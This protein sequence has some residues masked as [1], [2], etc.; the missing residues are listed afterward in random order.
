M[1]GIYENN[2]YSLNLE[3]DTINY[4]PTTWTIVHEIDK[5]SPLLQYSKQEISNLHGELIIMISYYDESFNQEVHQMHSYVLKEIRLDCKFTKV[6]YYNE[7]G[8]MVLD[9][10]L[11][12]RL[13]SSKS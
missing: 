5:N 10:K 12:D 1:K 7:K 8:K 3:G 6:Y 2:Y 4:L 13:E 9:Y 11:F